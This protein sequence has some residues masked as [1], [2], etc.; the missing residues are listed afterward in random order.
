VQQYILALCCDMW[1]KHRACVIKQAC[2]P[3]WKYV[4]ADERYDL[5][6]TVA[7]QMNRFSSE[8]SVPVLLAPSYLPAR[9]FSEGDAIQIYSGL[10]GRPGSITGVPGYINLRQTSSLALSDTDFIDLQSFSSLQCAP[11]RLSIVGNANMT[12]LRGLE[13]IAPA[14]TMSSVTI[15]GNGLLTSAGGF[16]PLASFL[17]CSTTLALIGSVDVQ[18]N[19]CATG[20][21]TVANLCKYVTSAP[22]T[23]CPS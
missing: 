7:L 6:G 3:G 8:P 20:I 1:N 15:R 16:A 5:V 9:Q 10:Q 12:S 22:E 23:A 4:Q 14:S 21:T 2:R 19:G 11:D 18:I 13:G 17:G